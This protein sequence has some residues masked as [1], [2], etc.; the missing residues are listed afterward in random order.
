MCSVTPAVLFK[1]L[2]HQYKFGVRES[3]QSTSMGKTPRL[4]NPS[5]MSTLLATPFTSFQQT[6]RKTSA[7]TL[8][9]LQL[10]SV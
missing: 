3:L 9:R 8:S 7:A 6:C 2:P 1:V 4:S 10:I 5:S